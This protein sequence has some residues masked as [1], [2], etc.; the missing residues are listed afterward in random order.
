M[1]A[2]YDN[3]RNIRVADFAVFELFVEAIPSLDEGYFLEF[4]R[5]VER[6]CWECNA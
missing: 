4:E 3:I 5:E 2:N 6:G 1:C